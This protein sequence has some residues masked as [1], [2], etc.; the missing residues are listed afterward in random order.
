VSTRIGG[1]IEGAL[2]VEDLARSMEF[3]RRVLGLA[4]ATPPL[5]RLCAFRINDDQVLL[6]F[7]KGGTTEP[8][9]TPFGVIPPND[10]DGTLHIALSIP[11][12]DFDDWQER[13]RGFGVEVESVVAWPEGGRSIYF[14]DPDRH[15]IELKTSNWYGRA[16]G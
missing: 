6:L 5:E 14:R 7:T 8:I 2:Y 4:P 10:G 15:L 9:V 12:A 16:L 1:I 13:L 11:P 3:Y